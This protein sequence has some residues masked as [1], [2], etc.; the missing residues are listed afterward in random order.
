MLSGESLGLESVSDPLEDIEAVKNRGSELFFRLVA[1]KQR[2]D[3]AVASMGLT[4]A[5][6]GSNQKIQMRLPQ[7]SWV[8][9]RQG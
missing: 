5:V 9:S 7:K 1:A 3:L 2:V 8:T 4:D 6:L